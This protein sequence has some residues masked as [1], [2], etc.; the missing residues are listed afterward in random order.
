[1][2]KLPQQ[3]F[4]PI[5][6]EVYQMLRQAILRG[7][8]KPG[9]R[10]QEETLAEQLGTSRTPVREA[11]RKLEVE[12]FVNYYPHRGTV[13]SEV[14]TDEIEELYQIRTIIE[15]FIAK[16]AAINATD[17]DIKHLREILANGE[18]LTDD[19]EILDN[20]EQF[21]ETIFEIAGS[22]S[23]ADLNRKI[24]ELLRRVVV[25]NHLDPQRRTR[26][27]SEHVRIV[28]AFEKNDPEL[29]QKVTI[30]HLGHSPRALKT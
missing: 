8:Y 2:E 6:D 19:I 22:R 26:A 9:D 17:K 13:V 27:H 14:S 30:E 7:E 16:R 24:R 18:K 29:A 25:S 12:S 23:L 11:L 21:N 3:R 20:I 5:R 28:D 15:S 10:L 4:R 1:M